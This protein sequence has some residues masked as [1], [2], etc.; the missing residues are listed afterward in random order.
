MAA[1]GLGRALGNLYESIPLKING[2]KLS[3]LLFP[4]PASPLALKIYILMKVCGQRYVLTNRSMQIWRCRLWRIA[5]L[6][7]SGDKLESEVP[8]TEV[9]EIMIHQS[10]GQVFYKASDLSLLA[11]G[12]TL[13]MQ[14][15]G[16]P[17]AEVFRRT[18]LKAR[19]ARRQVQ[20]SLE[21][22]AAREI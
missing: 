1:T 9:E 14:L 7:L 4:L 8:L 15:D 22:I 16:I 2:I 11:A 10:S 3:H 17:Y 21:T 12:G 5:L 13:L 6:D 18:I 20:A 19:D